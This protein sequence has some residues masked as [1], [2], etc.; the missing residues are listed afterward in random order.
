LSASS[1]ITYNLG[2]NTPCE[3]VDVA[4]QVQLYLA[5]RGIRHTYPPYSV[6]HDNK[7]SDVEDTT[8]WYTR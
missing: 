8:I 6:P 4:D 5:S 1:S 7:P 2:T 3:L